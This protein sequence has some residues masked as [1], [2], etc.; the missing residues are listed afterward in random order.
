MYFV[1]CLWFKKEKTQKCASDLLTIA[2][3]EKRKVKSAK[4]KAQSESAKRKRSLLNL[5]YDSCKL[6]RRYEVTKNSAK[7][8]NVTW[9]WRLLRIYNFVSDIFLIQQHSNTLLFYTPTFSTDVLSGNCNKAIIKDPIK[10]Q[11]C[12]EISV[13]YV[14]PN[15]AG[16]LGSLQN[17][18]IEANLLL[19]FG[20][21][22]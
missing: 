9:V 22:I 7:V 5:S 3:S 2:Q 8:E 16:G 17:T 12:R 20:T 14:V 10:P 19:P 4:W 21:K 13:S 1:A 11:T 18:E 15:K 6:S